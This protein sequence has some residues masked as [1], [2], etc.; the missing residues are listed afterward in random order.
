MI[1]VLGLLT[2]VVV[3]SVPLG[4]KGLKQETTRLAAR[5]NAAAQDS[6][7]SGR[8]YGF[9]AENGAYRFLQRQGGQ[10]RAVV[11]QPALEAHVLPEDLTIVVERTDDIATASEQPEGPSAFGLGKGPV[12]PTIRFHP[13][14][15]MTAFRV[16]LQ[17]DDRAY[18]IVGD[19]TGVIEME[20]VSDG[21]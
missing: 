7:I 19:E 1:L 17:S 16:T 21:G 18:V 2:G 4:D 15:L 12:V 14:G 3:L 5:L 20:E 9:L 10:W 11:G 8:H 13:I 6:V